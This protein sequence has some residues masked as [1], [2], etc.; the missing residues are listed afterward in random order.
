VVASTVG[1]VLWRRPSPAE[2][3]LEQLAAA[4]ERIPPGESPEGALLYT[5]SEQVSLMLFPGSD[6]PGL[7]VE[8]FA[9]LLPLTREIWVAADGSSRLRV[10][11]GAPTFFD[12][13]TARAFAGSAMPGLL[14][15]GT[16]SEETFAPSPDLFDPAD[17]PT[18]VDELRLAMH[19]EAR[20]GPPDLSFGARLVDVAAGLL[21]ETGAQPELRAAVLRVLARTGGLRVGPSAGSDLLLVSVTYESGSGLLAR[22]I[23]FD[24]SGNLISYT[25]TTLDGLPS[26]GVPPN[27]D[28][29]R[30]VYQPTVVVEGSGG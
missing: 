15:V 22:T 20:R 16:T 24:P 3:A 28:L 14:G 5:R 9:L 29:S 2:A 25:E 4:V 12:D 10:T 27:T 13:R 1:L 23:G 6:L 26:A 18:D 8:A 11:T 19:G 7:G 17:W 30:A 21:R